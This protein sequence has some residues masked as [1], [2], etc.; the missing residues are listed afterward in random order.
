MDKQQDQDEAHAR[1]KV[2][3]YF[4]SDIHSYLSDRD[5]KGGGYMEAA[6]H[7]APASLILDG[8]DN[9]QGSALSMYFMQNGD[10]F[11]SQM[12]FNSVGLDY[13][14]L[15]NHDFN[16][17]PSVLKRYMEG[18]NAV[19]LDSN[20]RS[21]FLP[22]RKWD[23][24]T[25]PDGTRI[26]L[27][28]AVTD[29]VN[30]WE[31][32]ENLE[33]IE[34]LDVISSAE[35]AF[36]E[37]KKMECDFIIMI[38]HG[39]YEMSR[40]FPNVKDTIENRAYELMEIG[41]DAVLCSHQHLVREPF[42]YNGC[43][44]LENGGNAATYSHLVLEKGKRIFAEVLPVS[45][46]PRYGNSS[47]EGLRK[48][49]APLYDRVE[50][51]KASMIGSSTEPFEDM[52]KFD[53]M[54][55]GSTLADFFNQVQKDISGADISITSLFNEEKRLGPE[56][57]VGDVISS[58]PFPNTL[59]KI[60]M[61]GE[62][63]KRSMERS[64]EFFDIA[65]DGRLR[66]SE[67]VLTPKVLFYDYNFYSDLEYEFDISRPVGDRVVKMIYNGIDLLEK[68]EFT[69]SV[70]V[71]NYRASGTG[72]YEV[73]TEC[74]VLKSYQEEL[75]ELIMDYFRKNSPVS[76]RR[77]SSFRVLAGRDEN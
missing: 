73:F 7:F 60:E 19:C 58:Y 17:G 3:I 16:Y 5:G 62:R 29:Y 69:L 53:G 55:H 10:I 33:G 65:E 47:L 2:D 72:G 49:L 63:I 1:L 21:S 30:V 59:V 46:G 8:G 41:F 51:F 42:E 22:V 31:K 27:T 40:I 34:I 70:A 9:L 77:R 37:L 32:K 36:R 6:S 75:P 74:P 26:G 67:R 52:D 18:L 54:I 76:L 12:A 61:T 25:A 43:M 14:T 11:P 48:S 24:Y 28:G 4:T 13:Y 38:Y 20:V 66:I 39:G 71:N 56:V 45:E 57:S 23:V 35:E 44:S 50:E 15:G 64:A 68:P